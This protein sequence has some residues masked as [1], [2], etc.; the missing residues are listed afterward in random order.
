MKI[1]IITFHASDNC[2]SQLQTYALSKVIKEH[3][4]VTPD[5]ID[6]SNR[7]QQEMYAVFRK[8]H[9]A[10]D[11]LRNLYRLL[12]LHLLKPYH[13]SFRDFISNHVHLTNDCYSL[14]EELKTL[15]GKYDVYI[16]GSDQVWN[17]RARDFDDS[18]FL[19]FVTKGRKV[20]YATSLGATNIIES[21]SDK[22]KYTKLLNDFSMLSV[23]EKN[24]QLLLQTI[25]D[26][27]VELLLDPT[28]LLSKNDWD[29]L[30]GEEPLI[31]GKYIFYYAF[32]YAE[33][34]NRIVKKLSE[35]YNMPV[36][37]V[38]AKAWALRR[39]FMDGFKLAP[40]FGP[41]AFLNLIKY[42]EL[43]LTTSFHG[44]ALS[45]A[46]GK[47]F[48]FIKTPMLNPRDDRAISLLNQLGLLD[49]LQG[50]DYLLSHDVLMPLDKA[51]SADDLKQ[52]SISYLA[53]ALEVPK[54]DAL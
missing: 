50:G 37:I 6:Y 53:R 42:S 1:A 39:M 31:K 12:F 44:T 45:V 7:R 24:A 32:T 23:R 14:P 40:K 20:A 49:R 34:P 3:F 54:Q 22:I 48:W 52:K 29:A 16:A 10:K 36:Y 15:D 19:D 30:A 41:V 18:Y 5:V 27:P 4:G 43:V 38:D 11:L 2:G 46:M 47:K 21:S 35:K 51:V 13:K 8:M 28:L 26:K 33:N 17:T 9:G 25:T